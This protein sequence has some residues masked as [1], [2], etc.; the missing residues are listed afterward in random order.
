MFRATTTKYVIAPECLIYDQ[1]VHFIGNKSVYCM[2]LEY[3]LAVL[4]NL[5][6]IQISPNMVTQASQLISTW[7]V[8]RL[9]GTRASFICV[10]SA[11]SEFQIASLFQ[12]Q[13]PVLLAQSRPPSHTSSIREVFPRSSYDRTRFRSSRNKLLV[14]RK[15][16]LK[17]QAFCFPFGRRPY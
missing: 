14:N 1:H 17:F 13:I 11:F 9:L 3:N 8:I 16:L 7:S 2:D 4:P 15:N 6:F 10:P 12:I 5:S